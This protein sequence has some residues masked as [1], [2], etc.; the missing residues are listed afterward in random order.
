LTLYNNASGFFA[1]R[2]PSKACQRQLMQTFWGATVHVYSPTTT[3]DT[4]SDFK[5]E[6]E[7]IEY[8]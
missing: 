5:P 6:K 1:N 4:E 8:R 3:S 7:K 2:L